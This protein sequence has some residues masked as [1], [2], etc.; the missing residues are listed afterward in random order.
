MLPRPSDAEADALDWGD[1]NSPVS[2]VEDFMVDVNPD[3]SELSSEHT[4]CRSCAR[5]DLLSQ[6]AEHDATGED[7]QLAETEKLTVSEP[8]AKVA[9]TVGDVFADN[10]V[11]LADGGLS[12]VVLPWE[13]PAVSAIFGESS[14]SS[15]LKMPPLSMRE[16]EVWTPQSPPCNPFASLDEPQEPFVPGDLASTVFKVLSDVDVD[17]Q[18]RK[19]VR[20]AVDKWIVIMQRNRKMHPE[21]EVDPQA[22]EACIGSR[23][24]GTASKRA[25]S[26]LTFLRWFDTIVG[27]NLDP[28]TDDMFWRYM[29]FLDG[30]QAPPSKASS[31]LSALRFAYFVM[32]VINIPNKISRKCV[33]AA[34]RM[35]ANLGDLKQ[36]PPLTVAQVR[37]LHSLLHGQGT[38]DWDRAFAG[39]C[40]LCLYA[41][42]R[43]SDFRKVAYVDVDGEGRDGYVV[44]RVKQHKTARAARRVAQLL[45]ILIPLRGISDHEWFESC[46]CAFE[47]VGLL[48]QGHVGAALFRPPLASGVLGRRAI[49]SGEV[50]TFLR[51][52]LRDNAVSSHSLKRTCISW[53]SKAGSKKEVRSCLGRHVTAVEGTEAVY[54]VELSMGPVREME[55]V[56]DAIRQLEF[57]PDAARGQM[58]AFPPQPPPPDGPMQGKGL[59]STQANL[60][61][62][63]TPAI[64]V[65]SSGEEESS[66]SDSSSESSGSS[67]SQ[68][69]RD[70]VRVDD[71]A[72]VPSVNPVQ[73]TGTWV[74]H[75]RS[76]VLHHAYG[77][78]ILVCGRPR[79]A[80]YVLPSE[81][82]LMNPECRTCKRN[83]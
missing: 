33:G 62:S 60:N 58:W 18:Q 48:L 15:E 5:D 27:A 73:G 51:L 65:E 4:S 11:R 54:S 78:N 83:L 22:L 21:C 25:G 64:K 74:K 39:Y 41:R 2:A 47:K 68:T 50:S 6:S 66:S 82:D 38:S 71:R 29:Q 36:A 26:I 75:S 34:E 53:T 13:L 61:A 40:L 76:G 35:L 8:P 7:S 56:L 19:A 70:P 55:T 32:D 37:I 45:P 43:Q 17:A 28:F 63:L 10:F 77:D 79:T 20:L 24:A 23:A 16:A 42:A 67:E 3:M 31:F 80:M 1:E 52:A 57:S 59:L 30:S 69:P 14:V 12:D 49:T 46:K 81:E 72:A 44:I 9:R